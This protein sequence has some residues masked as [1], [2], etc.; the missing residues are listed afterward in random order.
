MKLLRNF[1]QSLAFLSLSAVFGVAFSVTG[2]TAAAGENG[3]MTDDFAAD[4]QVSE[5]AEALSAT[6][7][8]GYFQVIRRDTRRCASPMCGGFFVKRV[9]EAKSTCADGSREAEC[10]VS[11]VQLSGIGLSEREEAEFRIAVENGTALIKARTYRSTTGGRTTGVLKANEG[12]LGASGVKVD[13]TFYRAAD[14]G[15]RCIT[16]PCPSTT[17]FGLNGAASYKVV[18]VLFTPTVFTGHT[19]ERARQAIATRKGTLVAG[20]VALP[21][22]RPHTDCGPLLIPTEI[23]TRVV[24]TE[25]ESCGGRAHSRTVCNEGQACFWSEEAICG[26]ADGSGDCGY[27]PEA[28]IELY[29]PVCGCDGATYGNSC[30]AAAAG[31]SVI[32]RGECIAEDPAKAPAVTGR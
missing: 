21:K 18:D 30:M 13:G 24:R 28:C 16:A 19:I 1:S 17:A 12:W 20:D 4:E 32:G 10:Y 9:N 7:N 2:C 6:T 31:V 14:N 15:I 5:S 11:A 22:C 25:G 23:Y 27:K 29:A 8:F 3:E 26:R